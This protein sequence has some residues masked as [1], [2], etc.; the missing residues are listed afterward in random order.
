MT[1][2]APH[3]NFMQV[4][5]GV[6]VHPLLFA[7]HQQP[8]LWNKN[9]ARLSKRGPHRDSDDIWLRY[10][11]ER[12]HI[13]S[14][15]WDG[16]CDPHIPEWYYAIDK[17]PQA[18][19]IIYD[20]ISKTKAEMLGGVLIYRVRPGKR[21]HPHVDTGWHPEFYDKFNVCLTSNARAHFAYT[22]ETMIQMPGDV[23]WFR[24]DVEHEVV[25]GGISDHII[26]TVCV[27]LDRGERVP[28][29]PEGWTLDKAMADMAAKE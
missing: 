21:I 27:R 4:A 18:R 11:D 20:I 2:S 28:A 8:E 9:P 29:S 10:K 25:N 7:I 1:S 22:D 13:E 12:P 19:P 16:F 5:S 3:K 6:D 17:L 23:H 14:N 15:S 26:M 24:N